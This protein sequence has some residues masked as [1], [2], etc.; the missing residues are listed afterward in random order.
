MKPLGSVL[1]GHAHSRMSEGLRDWLQASFESVFI[2]A[3]QPSLLDGAHKLQPALI[4]VDTA[5]ATGHLAAL[6]A[7]LHGLAPHSRI[8]LISG[9]AVSRSD[10]AALVPGRDGIVHT[11]A[12]AHELPAAVEAVIADQ[13][14][15]ALSVESDA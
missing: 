10:L 4:L 7:Q 2:V 5:L 3:D 8:V 14:F 11:A 9:G 13:D 12:L 1:V 6:M 15:K